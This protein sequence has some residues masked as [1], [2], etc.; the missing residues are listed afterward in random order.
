MLIVTV[1]TFQPVPHLDNERATAAVYCTADEILHHS[2]TL[3]THSTTVFYGTI[4]YPTLTLLFIIA[5]LKST[6]VGNNIAI[7]TLSVEENK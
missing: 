3:A 2:P 4:S 7:V 6:F 5:I 1:G